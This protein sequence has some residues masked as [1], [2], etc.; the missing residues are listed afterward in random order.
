MNEVAPSPAA[1]PIGCREQQIRDAAPRGSGSSLPARPAR[2]G[3]D[4]R[5]AAR[6]RESGG[7]RSLPS[8]C[9][10]LPSS[11]ASAQSAS[12]EQRSLCPRGS[13]ERC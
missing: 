7:G 2:P 3:R 1:A 8:L 9:L 12:K 4:A 6:Q 13:W 5:S 10:S 11:S